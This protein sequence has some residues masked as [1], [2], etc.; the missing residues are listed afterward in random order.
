MIRQRVVHFTTHAST[1]PPRDSRRPLSIELP[2][3]FGPDQ[4]GGA[5]VAISSLRVQFGTPAAPRDHHVERFFVRFETPEIRYSDSTREWGVL[6][7][8][9]VGLHDHG[10]FD[11]PFSGTLTLLILA[12]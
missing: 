3:T 1:T 5:W 7:R 10:D 4:I 12:S 11:D 8:G 9:E 2:V 6:V